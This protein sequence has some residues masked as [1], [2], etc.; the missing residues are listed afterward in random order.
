MLFSQNTIDTGTF[1]KHHPKPIRLSMYVKTLDIVT[2]FRRKRTNWNPRLKHRRLNIFGSIRY[3]IPTF[4]EIVPVQK[5]ITSPFRLVNGFQK[6]HE[7]YARRVTRIHQMDHIYFFLG[8]NRF[9][10]ISEGIKEFDLF[11]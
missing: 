7:T 8:R 1:D 11:P 2:L 10:F 3:P 4:D 9:F 6:I 5:S